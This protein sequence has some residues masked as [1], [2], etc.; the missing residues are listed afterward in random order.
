MVLTTALLLGGAGLSVAL[1]AGAIAPT[2]DHVTISNFMYHP[3]TLKVAPRATI[4]VTNTD[5]VV[6]TLSALGGQFNTGNILPHHTKTF[7]APK[8]PGRYHYICAIHQF[9]K[10]TIIV[11]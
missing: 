8:R 5:S 6:H 1:D 3:M 2:K 10:G 4:S 11:K 7:R 9:M